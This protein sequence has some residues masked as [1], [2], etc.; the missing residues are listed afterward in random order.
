MP[1]GLIGI[2][3]KPLLGPICKGLNQFTAREQRIETEFEGLRDAMA[4]RARGEFGGEIVDDEP[5]TDLDLDY[6][7]V[8]ME[9][10]RERPPRNGITEQKAFLVREVPWVTRFAMVGKI[11]GGRAGQN[12]RLQ[13]LARDEPGS[14]APRSRQ[15][16]FG[17]GAVD[18]C[19]PPDGELHA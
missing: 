4:G 3:R 9:L 12:A 1:R 8:A 5:P 11:D 6:L 14:T 17:Y 7:G 15:R 16:V 10:P 18:P 19:R 2:E 13:E